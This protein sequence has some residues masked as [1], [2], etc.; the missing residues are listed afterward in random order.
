MSRAISI[1]ALCAG[2]LVSTV[3]AQDYPQLAV[4]MNWGRIADANFDSRRVTA[5]LID[6]HGIEMDGF[7][8]LSN[9]CGQPDAG[10]SVWFPVFYSNTQYMLEVTVSDGLTGGGVE[11]FNSS[12]L[13]FDEWGV[14]WIYFEILSTGVNYDENGQLPYGYVLPSNCGAAIF[15]GQI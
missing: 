14:A 4:V 6:E 15:R 1:V 11:Y 9:Q 8:D 2:L 3:S 12:N 10:T 7:Q 13:L 5:R